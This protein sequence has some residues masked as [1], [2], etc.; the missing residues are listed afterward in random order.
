MGHLKRLHAPKTWPIK[1]KGITFISRPYP[2]GH[3]LGLSIPMTVLF[4]DCLGLTKTRKEVTYMMHNQEVLVDG[5]RRRDPRSSMGLMDVVT[6]PMTK[7]AYRLLINPYNLLTV[8]P[9]DEKESNKKLC[10]IVGKHIVKGGKMQ[11]ALHDGR[12]FLSEETY[13]VGDSLLLEVPTQKVLEHLPFKEGAL[14]YLFGGKYVGKTGVISELIQAKIVVA[15][16]EENLATLKEYAF[17]IGTDKP[18]I[19][20]E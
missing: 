12:T 18:V 9:V 8:V 10:K 7:E 13:A 6:L 19:K 1:R 2:G 16:G 11:Y 15:I 14:V 20:L 4:S 5:V 3:S 17:V